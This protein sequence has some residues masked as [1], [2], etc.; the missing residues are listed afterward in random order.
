MV[1][2][3]QQPAPMPWMDPAAMLRAT[4][5]KIGGIA[6]VR[7][8]AGLLRHMPTEQHAGYLRRCADRGQGAASQIVALMLAGLA[9][10]QIAE[11]AKGRADENENDHVAE[12]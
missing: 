10:M 7:Q 11:H 6:R 3:S 9:C 5:E 4:T 1:S 8:L 2:D 12:A